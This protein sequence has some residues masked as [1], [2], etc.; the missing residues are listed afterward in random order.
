M[1]EI[2]AQPILR[3]IEPEHG[4]AH[5]GTAFIDGTVEGYFAYFEQYA[6]K[7]LSDS[8]VY[9][10]VQDTMQQTERGDTWI[11]GHIVGFCAALVAD[12]D[13]FARVK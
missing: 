3:A 6:G 12:R 8:D 5:T 1:I 7:R 11:A 4:I 9:T 10:F 13:V 2:E